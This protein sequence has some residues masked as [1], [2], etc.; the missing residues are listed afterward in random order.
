MSATLAADES[1]PA[2]GSSDPARPRLFQ[3]SLTAVVFNYCCAAALLLLGYQFYCTVPPL[4]ERA[5]ADAATGLGRYW[6]AT[7][8]PVYRNTFAA[9]NA[10]PTLFWAVVAYLVALPVYYA[11]FPDA[12]EVKSR[13][14]WRAAARLI[15]LRR[16]TPAE[17]VAL[18]AVGVKAFFMPL[19]LAWLVP[20]LISLPAL[21]HYAAGRGFLGFYALAL[22]LIVIVDLSFFTVAYGVEHPR[23][24]NEVKSVEPTLLG[25]FVA[26]ICYPPLLPVTAWYLGWYEVDTPPY[27]TP[28]LAAL[29]GSLM[30]LLMGT[31]A[32]ASVALGLRGGNLTN[33][34]MVD[35]WPY[36][37]VRHPAYVCKNLFWCVGAVPALIAVWGRPF[38][39]ACIVLSSAAWFL[40]YTLRALTEE[41]HLL[42]DP[43][44]RAYC[45]RVRYRYVPGVW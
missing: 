36:S 41:R 8:F 31:Y 29:T 1:R 9:Q 24:G 26:L 28:W 30:L 11:T 4:L 33:R 3:A 17:A 7:G 16:P 34:G 42:A 15:R 32:A 10:A 2:P 13:L 35:R 40:V 37:V 23:L 22:T 44:Y 45:E 12:F 38:E 25:W 27:T 18:R 19:M 43:E 5:W 14:F 6:P 21:W 39:M 20:A